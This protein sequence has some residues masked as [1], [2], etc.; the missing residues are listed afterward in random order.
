MEDFWT[1]IN[2][3]INLDK[4]MVSQF[5][6]AIK[7]QRAGNLEQA[8]VS[9]YQSIE[10]NSGFYLNYHRLGET[11]YKLE[12]WQEAIEAFRQAVAV[13][14][15]SRLSLFYLGRVLAQQEH[16]EEAVELY[17]KAIKLQFNQPQVFYELG[18]A[19]VAINRWDE[20]LYAYQKT[21]ELDPGRYQHY[22]D[23]EENLLKYGNFSEWD[24]E[25]ESFLESHSLKSLTQTTPS[26]KNFLIELMGHSGVGKTSIMHK[27]K[28]LNSDDL[29]IYPS[30][31]NSIIKNKRIAKNDVRPYID[32]IK[33]R[34]FFEG[35]ISFVNKSSMKNSQ[36][37]GALQ[38]L[39]TTAFDYALIQALPQKSIVIHDELYMH[40]AFALLLYN[41]NFEEVV[42]WYYDNAPVPNAVIIFKKSHQEILKQLQQRNIP[43]NTLYGLSEPEIKKIY[44][45]ADIMYKIA[46]SVLEKRGVKVLTLSVPDTIEEA[47]VHLKS[48][49]S[50]VSI[51]YR[52]NTTLT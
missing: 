34:H 47:A 13:N 11:L 3:K 4:L 48:L 33:L 6:Q 26:Q 27:Y 14:P 25:P 9:Y 28:E 21:I 2:S 23:L 40:R 8:V 52:K 22:H 46:A 44:D 18:I 12:R 29:C 37:L 7:W 45:K 1:I 16:W 5:R 19:L 36:K 17:Q 43:I 32:V 20:A 35:C 31:V 30:I 49:I 10:K 51:P 15:S 41:D 50:S 42:S 24:I 39:R 38:M